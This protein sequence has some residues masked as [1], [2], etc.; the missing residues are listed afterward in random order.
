MIYLKFIRSISLNSSLQ[1]LIHYRGIFH[2]IG[3]CK[4]RAPKMIKVDNGPKFVSKALDQG[5]MEMV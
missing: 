5:P 3:E 2:L 4:Y 1:L